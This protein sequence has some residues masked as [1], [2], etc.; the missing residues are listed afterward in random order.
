MNRSV[1]C[2]V[3]S[4]VAALSVLICL[5]GEGVSQRQTVFLVA[6][7]VQPRGL[8]QEQPL[9]RNTRNIIGSNGLVVDQEFWSG[10]T[11][12][13]VGWVVISN[14]SWRVQGIATPGECRTTGAG[15]VIPDVSQGKSLVAH[16]VFYGE[17]KA[18]ETGVPPVVAQSRAERRKVAI[19]L[20]ELGQQIDTARDSPRP[21]MA[22]DLTGTWK[23][24]PLG[25][26]YFVR[27]IG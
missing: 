14:M 26:T 19:R 21:T 12:Q 10:P 2:H 1:F 23:D 16:M 13:C 8:S 11:G 15:S 20:H 25:G 9:P 6:G 22:S 4:I 5:P 3:R 7:D 27:Q 17:G 24:A 18:D